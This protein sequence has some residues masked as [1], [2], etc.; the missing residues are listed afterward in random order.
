MVQFPSIITKQHGPPNTGEPK[1]AVLWVPQL[2]FCSCSEWKC[3][4]TPH[5]AV[6]CL[7]CLLPPSE[8]CCHL[9]PD[10]CGDLS[11]LSPAVEGT[12]ELQ[13][14]QKKTMSEHGPSSAWPSRHV[15]HRGNSGTAGGSGCAAMPG[16]GLWAW[17]HTPSMVPSTELY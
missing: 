3:S 11:R 2:I 15:S 8:T 5:A 13:T 9:H 10:R 4:P 1:Q 17:L 7:L 6:W 12:L 16:A 14:I